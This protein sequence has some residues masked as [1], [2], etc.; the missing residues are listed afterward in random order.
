MDILIP[1]IATFAFGLFVFLVGR[2]LQSNERGARTA[3]RKRKTVQLG[4]MEADPRPRTREL[5]LA[6][7]G[8][9]G[10]SDM[11]TTGQQ[12]FGPS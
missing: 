2:Y 5:H 8:A 4:T 7:M 12:K 10:R 6:A 1:W 9:G 3:I 11:A